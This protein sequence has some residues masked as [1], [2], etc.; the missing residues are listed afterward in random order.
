MNNCTYSNRFGPCKDGWIRVE[1]GRGCVTSD[2]CPISGP[3][4]GRVT[5]RQGGRNELG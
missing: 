3:I 1:D 2:L 4:W 5:M